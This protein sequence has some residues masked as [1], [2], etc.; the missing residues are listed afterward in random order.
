MADDKSKIGPPDS[1]R[2]NLDE[3][4]E[5]NYWTKSLG[6]TAGEL[7]LAV[8]AMGTSVEAVRRYFKK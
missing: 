7:R 6:C 5:V 3:P 1:K 2:I 8:K 4:Y